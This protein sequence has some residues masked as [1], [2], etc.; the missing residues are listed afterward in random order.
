MDGHLF[1]NTKAQEEFI[2]RT[3]TNVDE[4]V[5]KYDTTLGNMKMDRSNKSYNA[6]FWGEHTPLSKK[7]TA[8]KGAA[9]E[10]NLSNKKRRKQRKALE[11]QKSYGK[12]RDIW[13]GWRGHDQG[14]WADLS[15][16]ETARRVEEN[17]DYS[18]FENLDGTMRA[19]LAKRALKRENVYEYADEALDLKN[20]R[21]LNYVTMYE[22]QKER[23]TAKL[24]CK[25][26]MK[27]KGVAALLDPALR[28]GLSMDKENKYSQKLDAEMSAAVML[29]TLK[30]KDEN[31]LK[32]KI[33]EELIK[34]EKM[35]KQDALEDAQRMIKED[36]AQ[37]IQ[38]AKRLL[39]LHLALYRNE[40]DD[41]MSNAPVTELLSHGRP[42]ILNLPDK[43]WEGESEKYH[44]DMLN[45]IFYLEGGSNLAQ[46]NRRAVST[47]SVKIR[48]VRYGHTKRKHWSIISEEGRI[49]RR[50][51][52][53][54]MN[55]A[56]G[57]L[58]N[59]GLNRKMILND[60]SC[61]HFYSM[62]N[63]GNKGKQN[64][65]LMGL[66]SAAP[67]MTDR[68][69]HTH[70]IK[71]APEKA[72]CLGGQRTDQKD[73][74]ELDVG[75]DSREVT[76]WVKMLEDA[77]KRNPPELESVLERLVGAPLKGVFFDRFIEDL[78]K[79]AG[80]D[81]YMCAISNVGKYDN[82]IPGYYDPHNQD[83][84]EIPK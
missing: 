56:I 75:F 25:G 34:N 6:R 19:M 1:K 66:E 60:G 84:G 7:A 72:S 65:I 62:Y 83:W 23:N 59:E 64:F 2:W 22:L 18:I 67:G 20:S 13:T 44:Q 9:P 47:H 15:W 14:K 76:E 39:L 80:V 53:R 4:P 27:E 31:Q 35:N 45:S 38:T 36:K 29:E 69:G 57:G 12:Q 33:S 41:A 50:R 8:E 3:F 61:G 5:W 52:Q 51:N 43:R 58:G 28:L 54:G 26:L 77:M 21:G 46:D 17:E 63:E 48:K 30:Q 55:V 71:S 49:T 73:P 42:V 81:N 78:A 40:R 79:C 11:K 68:L 82:D 32:E 37:K 10:D 16:N 74:Y 70:D 24:A